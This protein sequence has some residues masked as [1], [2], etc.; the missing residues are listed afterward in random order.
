MKMKYP[1]LSAGILSL[2]ILMMSKS[3]LAQYIGGETNKIIWESNSS[4]KIT[5]R[6]N[7]SA[8]IENH[9]Y[10]YANCQRYHTDIVDRVVILQKIIWKVGFWEG[11]NPSLNATAF[12]IMP[13]GKQ[14]I[15][16]SITEEADE[17]M[18]KCDYYHTIW[19]GC[20]SSGP[21]HRLYNPQTGRLIMEYSNNLLSVEIPNTPLKRYVGYKPSETITTN[22]WEKDKNHIGTLTYSSPDSILH[23]IALKMVDDVDASEDNFGLG[24]A[25]I[26]IESDGKNKKLNENKLVLWEA[27]YS[28]DPKKFENFRI[29][30][31]FYA[32]YTIVV[33]VREDNFY[34]EQTRFDDYEIIIV[35]D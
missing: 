20:C 13:D 1:G 2:A 14:E 22:S 18:L 28:E 24:F 4:S 25:S 31:V 3:S 8:D 6:E 17:G 9:N 30:I 32:G 15:L 23:R 12:K 26:S 11:N 33:P 19:H 16:W 34:L 5:L 27:N 21:N 7:N 29:K 35:S 10:L